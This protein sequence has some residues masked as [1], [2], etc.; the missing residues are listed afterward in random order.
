MPRFMTIDVETTGVDWTTC[1]LHG[2]SVG[3]SDTEYVDNV[4]YYMFDN[5][6]NQVI[7]DLADSK[8]AKIGHNLR[9]DAK[10]LRKAG[11][12]INGQ[13]DDTMV[14][15]NLIND[16][17]PLGLKFLAEKYLGEDSLF[18]KREL[19]KY[20]KF[21]NA[22]H[23]GGLCALDLADPKRPHSSIIA[24]YCIEDNINTTKLLFLGIKRLK[25]I[26][27]VLKGP[28]FNFKKSPLDYY[29]EEARPL[30]RV[31]FDMEYRGL[32][33]D[34]SVFERLKDAA[35]TRMSEIEV[36]LCTHL[37]KQIKLVELYIQDIE[38]KKV[39]TDIAKAKR[40]AGQGKCK[41]SWGNN[42]H[43]GVLIYQYC[44]LP[45]DLMSKTKKGKYQTDKLTL[46]A[47]KLELQPQHPL[48]E[49]LPLFAE[50][51][52]HSKIANTYTGDNEKGVMS[53]IRFING[54]PRIFP[55][56][57][58]TTGTGRLACKNPNMQNLKRDSEIKKAF[59]PDEGDIFDDADYSQIELRTGAHLSKDTG[60]VD[61]YVNGEDVHLRTASRLFKKTITKADDLERQAGKRTNFLTIFDGKEYRLMT[62]LKQDTGKDFTLDECKEFIRVWFETYP[63][64]RRYLNQQLLFFKKHGFCISETGRV[65]RL[66]DI[67]FGNLKWTKKDH[68]VPVFKGTLEQKNKL[69]HILC[70]KHK[71]PAYDISEDMIGWEASKKYKHAIKAGYN[72]PIQG[73]AASMTKRSMIELH[74]KGMRLV[75]Q[76]HDSIVVAR[77]IQDIN[78]KQDLIHTMENVYK[79]LVPVKVDVKTLKSFHPNDK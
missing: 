53:K 47:L 19:D 4:G 30:E 8:I 20:I 36:L 79:L 10:I 59:I 37:D 21:H 49:C 23:I 54:I 64:V 63:D 68:W 58:Q 22:G 41:F 16:T 9:F 75:N 43:V 28:K 40:V 13:F 44:G 7:Q 50:Y 35:L 15:F 69:I 24:K 48:L 26:D 70:V 57:R 72:Q 11:F 46:E 74:N 14:V 55:S 73:L 67:A 6:P 29:L 3:Y 1:Q 31:L 78:G 60:L 52:L 25:E 45:L 12:E 5:I 34:L 66:P 51:K 42:N 17:T 65:R 18:S 2:V 56:Y 71:R 61:A 77:N 38:R 62:S 27:V 33:V 39:S 76:V 32:R